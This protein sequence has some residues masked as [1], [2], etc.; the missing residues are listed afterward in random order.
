MTADDDTLPGR[1]LTEPIDESDAR[2]VVPLASMLRRY[3]AH[4]G[5]DAAGL[6]R[7]A[8]LRRL[9]IQM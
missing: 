8:L 3:Y 4:R 5:W 9:H 7:A 1:D 2:S 6:P